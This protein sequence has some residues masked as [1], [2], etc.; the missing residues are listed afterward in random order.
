MFVDNV[1]SQG[2]LLNLRAVRG[3]NIGPF[4]VTWKDEAG[5]AVDITGAQ[6]LS[7]I[8]YSKTQ[9]FIDDF[10]VTIV[11]AAAGKFSFTLPYQQSSLLPLDR[12]LAYFLSITLNDIKIPLLYGR[13][14]LRPLL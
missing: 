13:L 5:L 12:D 7:R 14:Y 3:N 10:I 9:D 2:E 1:G 6:F 11:D 4:E 8:R